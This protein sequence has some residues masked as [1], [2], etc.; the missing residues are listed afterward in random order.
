MKPSGNLKT[1]SET[2]YPKCSP[3][4]LQQ[5]KP[6]RKWKLQVRYGVYRSTREKN[7]DNIVTDLMTI[8]ITNLSSISEKKNTIWKEMQ[9]I[10]V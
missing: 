7:Y 1:L 2:H 6:C 4:V 3:G 8:N 5:K 10:L 9:S